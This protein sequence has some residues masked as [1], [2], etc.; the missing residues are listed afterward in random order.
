MSLSEFEFKDQNAKMSHL[1]RLISLPGILPRNYDPSEEY[2][3]L[4]YIDHPKYG[5]GFVLETISDQVISV[6]FL[7]EEQERQIPQRT[8]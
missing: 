5:P 8:F 6:F 2:N 7:K 1:K 3:R 4:D